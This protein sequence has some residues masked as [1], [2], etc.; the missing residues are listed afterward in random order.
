M[1]KISTYGIK[2]PPIGTDRVI[3]TDTIG[4]PVNQT[5]NFSVQE[6][7]EYVTTNYGSGEQHI[8]VSITPTEVASLATVKKVLIPPQ[9]AN[10]AIQLT[11]ASI[12]KEDD[13]ITGNPGYSF[14]GGTGLNIFYSSVPLSAAANSQTSN[15]MP[16]FDMNSSGAIGFRAQLNTNSNPREMLAGNGLDIFRNND[17]DSPTLGG[18]MKVWLKY[19]IF[20][21]EGSNYSIIPSTII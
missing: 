20:D 21:I 19:V 14:T 16:V 5:K 4:P 11:E 17:G 12:W 3:G 6:L 1:A 7:G 13:S 15:M 2:S 9:G 10:T 18:A 8:I